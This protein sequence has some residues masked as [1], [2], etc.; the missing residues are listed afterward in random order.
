MLTSDIIRHGIGAH[1]YR[2]SDKHSNETKENKANKNKK[3]QNKTK[4]KLNQYDY[5]F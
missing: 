2:H 3:K 4:Q 1:T 5:L